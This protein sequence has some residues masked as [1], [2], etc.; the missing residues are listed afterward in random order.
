MYSVYC[1]EQ[2]K[3]VAQINDLENKLDKHIRRGIADQINSFDRITF[4][5]Q[6]ARRVFISNDSLETH[7]MVFYKNKFSYDLTVTIRKDEPKKVEKFFNSF[8]FLK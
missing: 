1:I 5:D 2:E 7:R 8:Q 6:P 3:E 4:L